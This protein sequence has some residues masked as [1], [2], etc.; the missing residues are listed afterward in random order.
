MSTGG[1]PFDISGD[2]GTVLK[3]CVRRD[4][5]VMSILSEHVR[6]SKPTK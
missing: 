5:D 2:Y 3:L 6:C 4:V 1:A